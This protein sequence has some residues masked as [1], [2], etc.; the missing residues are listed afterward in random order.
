MLN[1]RAFLKI[2]GLSALAAAAGCGPGAPTSGANGEPTPAAGS[3]GTPAPPLGQ[4]RFLPAPT[5]VVIT[6][7]NQLYVQSYDRVARVNEADWSLTLDGLAEN[8][9]TLSYADVLAMPKVTE[10]RTLQCIGNPVGG[11]LVGNVEWGGFLL[12][13]L[14]ERV[15]VK[16]EAIR[17]KFRAADGYETSVDLQWITQPGVMMA[18]EIN[19][20]PLPQEHGYPLRILMPG[21]YGQKMP[22]WIERIEFIDNRFL[23]YWER[24]GWSDT[25]DVQTNSIIFQPENLDEATLGET[26]PIYGIA[27]AG[28]RNITRVEVQVGREDTWQEAQL[29]QGDSSLIWSQWHFDWMADPTGN[30]RIAVRAT[31]EDGF[32]QSTTGGGL[33]Q[34]AFPN[35]TNK[36]HSILVRVG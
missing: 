33:L 2:A 32:M 20:E 26:V 23:G 10:I 13:D 3:G 27:F 7:T 35:G 36:V 14:L 25:A 15:Q 4:G 6:P 1:R 19:G 18:Y 12:S 21:L 9:L 31:D 34:G 22:K 30:A 24:N 5:Q 29:L 8:P 11:R 16:P 28:L 17:A